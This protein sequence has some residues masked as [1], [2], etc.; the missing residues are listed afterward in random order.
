MLSDN[1]PRGSGDQER[2]LALG[3]VALGTVLAIF[4]RLLPYVP[5]LS[6]LFSFW[7]MGALTLYGSARLRSWVA[8]VPPLVAMLTVDTIIWLEQGYRPSW[9]IYLS[10]LGYALI[11]FLVV[12]RSRSPWRIGGAAVLGTVQWFLIVEL[13]G[14]LRGSVD[15]ALLPPGAAYV[16]IPALPGS[17]P[18]FHYART[19]PGLLAR[20]LFGLPFAL[21]TLLADLSFTALFFGAHAYLSRMVLPRQRSV[22]PISRPLEKAS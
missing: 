11:G 15:P 21:R 3:I 20:Y 7:V 10:L 6:M 13:V 8:L 16:Q 1:L 19:L 14:W 9:P 22:L 18:D 5:G 4:V 12:G 17:F 2:S